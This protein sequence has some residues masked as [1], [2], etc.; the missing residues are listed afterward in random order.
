MATGLGSVWT[1]ELSPLQGNNVAIESVTL[2]GSTAQLKPK[3]REGRRVR[4]R[5][6]KEQ[7]RRK[8]REGRKEAREC[9]Q[10]H[11]DEW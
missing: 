4:G 2:I 9:R 7:E 8:E 10:V 11:G 1:R 6:G 3:S 5:R